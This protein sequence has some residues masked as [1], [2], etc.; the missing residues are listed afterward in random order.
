MIDGW[1]LL[2][3]WCEEGIRE[4]LGYSL[5]TDPLV[6]GGFTLITRQSA[7]KI[8]RKMNLAKARDPERAGY[9]IPVPLPVVGEP[10]DA[11]PDGITMITLDGAESVRDVHNTLAGIFGEDK[12]G[13]I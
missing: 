13:E 2:T 8:A 7:E 11:L 10:D 4:R 6:E 12:I 9:V 1:N 3:V 5:H